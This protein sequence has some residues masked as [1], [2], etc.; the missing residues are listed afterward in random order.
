MRDGV[1][2]FTSI[3]IPKGARSAPI[4]LTRT[5]YKATARTELLTV[6]E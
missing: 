1:K 2:L 4:L 6:V 5:P 3:V